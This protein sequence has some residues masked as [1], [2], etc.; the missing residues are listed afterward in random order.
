MA[1]GSADALARQVASTAEVRWSQGGNRHVH[2]TDDATRFVRDLFA[3]EAEPIS[4]LEVR[5]P[6]L[7]STYLSMVADE[8]PALEV[9]P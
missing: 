5:R 8:A 4:D 3:H 9:V 1:N 6:S 7:E 2:A